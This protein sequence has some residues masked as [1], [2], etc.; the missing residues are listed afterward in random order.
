MFRLLRACGV[1]LLVGSAVA[2][3]A[4][5]DAQRSADGNARW[6]LVS[7]VM[8]TAE[9]HDPEYVW[10]REGEIPTSLTTAL[11]GK[12]AVIAPPHV[13]PRY[14]PPPG[15]GQISPFQGGPYAANQPGTL[16]DA[17]A[18]RQRAAPTTT[19][20]AERAAPGPVAALPP[21][22]TP[23]VTPR[24]YVVYIDAKRIVIDLTVQHGLK[25]GDIVRVTREKLP[26][27]HPITGVYLGESTRTSGQRRS[28]SCGKVP[29]Q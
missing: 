26:L 8:H 11:F 4:Q 29:R 25:R 18:S 12:K 27:V 21:G 5:R 20:P 6:V 13:V 2:G 14:S 10:V 9:G 3:C 1:A 22:A 7:N 16:V 24:G 28:S 17:P 15:G 19:G 23:G